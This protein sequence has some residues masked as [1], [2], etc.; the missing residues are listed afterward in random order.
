M[1]EFDLGKMILFGVVALLVVGPNEL[2]AALRA[3][4]RVI[5][6]VKRVKAEV[7]KSVDTLMADAS[8]DRELQS[9]NETMRTNLALDPATAMRGS[10][11]ASA[12]K[13]A[14]DAV[15]PEALE[16]ASPEM[17]AYLSPLAEAAPLAEVEA[18]STN[19]RPVALC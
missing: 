11:P 15:E 16:Y 12:V 6:K 13:Q 19:P 8:L 4:G 1:F 17:R 2:P 3:A 18:T 5:A 9:L 14:T 7:W 10:L